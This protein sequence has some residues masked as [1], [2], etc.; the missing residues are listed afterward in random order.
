M[1]REGDWWVLACSMLEIIFAGCVANRVSDQ[2][3]FS[4]EMSFFLCTFVPRL[5]SAARVALRPLAMSP[6]GDGCDLIDILR[7]RAKTRS[8]LEARMNS[9]RRKPQIPH[10]VCGFFVRAPF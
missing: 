1:V 2:S 7:R 9:L 3:I 4:E 10:T 6:S 8:G 5:P